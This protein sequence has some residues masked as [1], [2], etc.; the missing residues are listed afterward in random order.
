MKNQLKF[1]SILLVSAW[2]LIGM[3]SFSQS[4]GII[5]LPKNIRPL[6]GRFTLTNTTAIICDGSETS[7]RNAEMLNKAISDQTGYRLSVEKQTGKT[8]QGIRYQIQAIDSLGKEGYLLKIK[9]SGIEIIAAT[10]NGL[11][12][13]TQ[14]L[15]Q[16]ISSGEVAGK[17]ISLNCQEIADSPRF[18]WRGMMLDCSRYFFSVEFIKKLLDDLSLHKIN[19]FHWHLT[20][21]PGWRIEIKAFPK[22]T[23]VGAFRKE[24][25]IGSLYDVPEK[26]DGKPYGGF[27]SQ[28]DIKEIVK[29]AADRFITIVPE[30][31]MPGHAQAA[32][33]AYPWLG[34]TDVPAEVA[35][36]WG[37]KPYL[38]N[39]FD[40][41]FYFLEKV[42]TEVF[43]LFPGEYVHIGGDEA[44][45]DQWKAN[46]KIQEK[47]KELGLKNENELQSWFIKRIQKFAQTKNKKIIGWDEI[48]EG[49][50]P[51]DAAIMFWRSGNTAPLEDAVKGNHPVV[52]T[53]TEFCYLDYYQAFPPKEPLSMGGYL[54]LDKV[55]SMD[56]V[57]SWCNKQ[58]AEQIMGTQANLW[59]E[60]ISSPGHA[61]YMLYPRLAAL[62]EVAWT[63][64]NLKD[65]EDFA[66]RLPALLN[67]Y[68]AH[69]INYCPKQLP[70]VK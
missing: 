10:P 33:T 12:Y 61:E 35:T 19:T 24:T 62:A 23:S 52:A 47:I 68:K 26:Y 67:I 8:N 18:S 70:C 66:K 29:Y 1:C 63:N 14:S 6:D 53:P 64:K 15:V 36:K 7:L 13:S 9:P 32:I 38:Y 60:Y 5:P 22:L 37:V 51:K 43:E 39:P 69:N 57:P 28:N 40:T 20:D 49:G 59:T 55:Y 3:Q 11:F 2:I 30:I 48:T 21:D 46:P 25:L 17:T 31:E 16:L 44:I 58:Q 54:T 34:S 42:L 65:Y 27:Y 41:T 45:K 4:T 56:P 50:A